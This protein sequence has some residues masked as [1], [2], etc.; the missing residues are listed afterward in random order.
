M[1]FPKRLLK[2]VVGFGNMHSVDLQAA[3]S[4]AH[5]RALEQRMLVIDALEQR[6]FLEIPPQSAKWSK[7][8]GQ[9]SSPAAIVPANLTTRTFRTTQNNFDDQAT[10]ATGAVVVNPPGSSGLNTWQTASL[11]GVV[12]GLTSNATTYN[13]NDDTE[14]V[15]AESFI[16]VGSDYYFDKPEY[17]RG[18]LY[19]T[20]ISGYLRFTSE[21]GAAP[22]ETGFMNN[23][24]IRLKVIDPM[25]QTVNVILEISTEKFNAAAQ[26]NPNSGV[27]TPIS[28]HDLNNMIYPNYTVATVVPEGSI[29][30]ITLTGLF[31]NQYLQ[32]DNG[33][34]VDLAAFSGCFVDGSRSQ[35]N[36]AT[37]RIEYF[38]SGQVPLG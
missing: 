1:D 16:G 9:T 25:Q 23:G 2:K 30:Q 33:A 19:S 4:A 32:L 37:H 26:D 12:S 17:A 20:R 31:E 15:L 8:F 3:E 35:F 18:D 11:T 21:I 24:V 7:F 28:P 27:G 36:I 10:V 5:Q 38:E 29:L 22:T 14:F 13:P 6:T 34:T